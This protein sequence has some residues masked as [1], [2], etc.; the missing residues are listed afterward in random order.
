MI[1][2]IMTI[3]GLKVTKAGGSP[4][5][6]LILHGGPGAY[7]YIED[8]LGIASSSCSSICY[9]QR[10]GEQSEIQIEIGIKTHISDLS[11]VVE[12]QFS[13][14]KPIL[15]GHSWGAMLATLFAGLASER[16]EKIIM[17][18]VGPLDQYSGRCFMDEILR[19][20]GDKRA[21]FDGL[22]ENT[23]SEKDLHKQ[24]LLANQYINE[25]IPYYQNEIGTTQQIPSL[26]WDFRGSYQTML[27]SDHNI[28]SGKYIEALKN[29][30]CPI[31]L[32]HG[33][34][35]PLSPDIIFPIVKKCQPSA[36]LHK[37]NDAGHYPWYGNGKDSFYE[38]FKQ[39]LCP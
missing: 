12:S 16:I 39:E 11:M 18:G 25:V 1:K 27:E 32:I 22:W 4:P 8:L 23:V 21:Y 31:T 5:H 19:R 33:C 6:A 7:G 9:N 2:N 3:D 10:G 26:V 35:D 14:V 28:E 17:I 36:I 37:I 15:I 20:F 38:V 29:I 34:E 24:Q 13:D 30:Q